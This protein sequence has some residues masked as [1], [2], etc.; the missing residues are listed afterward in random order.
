MYINDKLDQ[1][2]KEETST[3]YD[4]NY[5][6]HI[7]FWLIYFSFNI[8]RWGS[9]HSDFSYSLKTNLIGFPIHMTIAYFNIYYLMPKFVYTR[10]YVTYAFLVLLS[11]FVMLL[12]KF[13]L[14][15]Y[16]AGPNVMPE[17]S[18]TGGGA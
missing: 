8:L 16:I 12:V 5:K 13:N 14:T 9:L 15:Y 1:L 17:A 7:V 10:R 4:I 11:L 6:H 3:K 18:V 2:L